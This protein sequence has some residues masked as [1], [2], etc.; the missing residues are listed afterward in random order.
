MAETETPAGTFCWNE[1]ATNDVEGAKAFYSGLL[2]WEFQAMPMPG[3]PEDEYILI[4][5]GGRGVGG[6]YDMTRAPM[7]GVP[8]HWMGYI[9]V[10][11]VDPV[12]AAAQASGATALFPPM[13][14]PGVGRM[15]AL[16]DPQGAAFSLYKSA[17]ESSDM[18]PGHEPG[19]FCWH[20]LMSSDSDASARFYGALLPWTFGEMALGD[21]T[22]RTIS[23]GGESIGGID[24]MGL[25]WHGIPPHWLAYVTVKDCDAAAVHA[26]NLGGAICRPPA[27]VPN[28][29][30]FAVLTD[31]AG[32]LFAIIQLGG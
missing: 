21:R 22:Y 14:I 16:L 29:G 19:G 18:L 1:L 31:P 32:A 4:C 8:P 25:G 7:E 13:D 28:V 20:E 15:C 2:G 23:V 5:K 17:G 24:Q 27:D 6:L 9:A 10:D 11:E 3:N 26:E 12:A 30:R